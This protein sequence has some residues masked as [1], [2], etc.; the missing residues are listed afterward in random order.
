MS[1]I[2][3]VSAVPSRLLALL[4]VLEAQSRP[5]ARSDLLGVIA[6]PSLSRRNAPDPD[7]KEYDRGLLREAQALGLIDLTG[8]EVSLTDAGRSAAT[9]PKDWFFETLTRPDRADAA[10]QGD[11][12]TALVWLLVQDPLS[13]L[14]FQDNFRA[15]LEEKFGRDLGMSNLTKSQQFFHWARFLGF[16]WWFGTDKQTVVIPDPTAALLHLLQR[17]TL[18]RGI[19]I[20]VRQFLQW[21]GDACPVLEGGVV[22]QGLSPALGLDRLGGLEAGHF[23]YSTGVALERLQADGVLQFAHQSDADLLLAGPPGTTSL[24]ISHITVAEG[25][26]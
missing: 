15:E 7:E 14:R 24:G 9:A 20:P 16:S 5:W 17:S 10:K 6:P 12:P 26:A 25:A 13:G 1:V 18:P 8:A 3:T 2:I 21:L 11:F 19:S 22:R 4:G 23:S